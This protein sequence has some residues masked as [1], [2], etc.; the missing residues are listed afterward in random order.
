M[1]ALGKATIPGNRLVAKQKRFKLLMMMMLVFLVAGPLLGPVI[2]AEDFS[3][4]SRQ[5]RS[6]FYIGT[7]AIFGALFSYNFVLYWR[8]TRRIQREM[9][10]GYAELMREYVEYLR[11]DTRVVVGDLQDAWSIRIQRPLLSIEIII[12]RLI[13]EW[14]VD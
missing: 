11:R 5:G 3:H 14:F 9:D 6:F 4:L 1:T 13:L 7:P 2:F 10:T 8:V 12:P